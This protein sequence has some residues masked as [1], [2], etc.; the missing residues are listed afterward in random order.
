MGEQHANG[1][2]VSRHRLVADATAAAGALGV[3]RV[4]VS[5]GTFGVSAAVLRA[6]GVAQRPHAGGDL[7]GGGGLDQGS[8][9]PAD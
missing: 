3:G 6:R 5:T 8:H 4:L 2:R 1:L 7:P 9:I